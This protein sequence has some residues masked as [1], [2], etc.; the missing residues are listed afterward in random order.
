MFTIGRDPEVLAGAAKI[1][2]RCIDVPKRKSEM[3]VPPI[4][5]DLWGLPKSG[6]DQQLVE[7]DRWFRR[8][9]FS[10][11][12]RQESA[13]AEDIRSKK[14]V[15]PFMYEAQ[16]FSYQFTNLLNAIGS[17]DFHLIAHNRC[18][19]DELVWY[20]KMKRTGEITEAQHKAVTAFVFSG[21]WLE[22]VSAFVA[23]TCDI[24]TA[25]EREY[26][27]VQGP[28][29]HGSRMNPKSL[30]LM[31]E[32][33]ESVYAELQAHSPALPLYRV[34]TT[35]RSIIDVRDEILEYVLSSAMKR[36]QLQE[37]DLL[38]WCTALLRQKAWMS[39]PEL[40]FR[41]VPSD[42]VLRKCGW[43]FLATT[44]E[45][46]IYLTPR[47]EPSST[48]NECFHV[49][50]SGNAWYFIYKREG[51]DSR[52]WSKLHVPVPEDKVAEMIAAFDRVAVVR[53]RRN[54]FT[55]HEFILNCDT[56]EGLGEFIEIKSSM[57]T[58]DSVLLDLARNLGFH[59]SD[60]CPDSY[61]NL[62]RKI[63]EPVRVAHAV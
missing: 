12:I 29:V 55:Y 16:H 10:V 24:E 27:H 23:L 26:Q 9:G 21:P 53:K 17:R 45:E 22:A 58:D 36:L 38:P 63:T 46:D 48:N 5:L 31:H 43:Q 57:P 62:Q 15:V 42:E 49:R 28:I 37:N 7:L 60:I 59:E 14:R 54:V 34:D 33:F 32:C 35:G 13:E 19:V 6:K 61:V 3:P 20:E 52:R 44:V 2:L 40:K 18:M 8:Q 1:V 11:L 25:L 50:K 56:V 51:A 30:K 4:I 41:G 47:G 39:G